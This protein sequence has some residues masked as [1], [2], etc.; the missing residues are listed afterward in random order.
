MIGKCIKCGMCC[1]A[2][3]LTFGMENIL[4]KLKEEENN[5]LRFM[6]ENFVEISK[7]EAI[8]RNPYLKN[9]K[10]KFKFYKC[11]KWD[12]KTKLCTDY[13]N[14]G[15]TCKNYPFGYCDKINL[16]M[17][18]YSEE[19]G[20]RID[21]DIY[22]MKLLY[23]QLLESNVEE[24]EKK[25]KKYFSD[26]LMNMSNKQKSDVLLQVHKTINET[27]ARLMKYF[28]LRY[29]EDIE[30]EFEEDVHGNRV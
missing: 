18:F 13:E 10:E 2:V 27:S 1:C 4:K 6:V 26:M 17:F 9:V 22:K 5:D 25:L 11:L 14:R 30:I 7:E 23:K 29:D 20:H 21:Y 19:C 28:F 15:I 24:V 16:N 3:T 12:E 8:K